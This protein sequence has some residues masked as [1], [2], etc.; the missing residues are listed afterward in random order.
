MFT[1]T[2]AI[3]LRVHPWSN[4][5]H[6]V[7]WLT[8]DYGR[9]TTRIKGACRP[10]SP[11]LGQYDLAYTCELIFYTRE[12]GGVHSIREVSPLNLRE[13][14]RHNWRAAATANYYI[15]LAARVT[16]PMQE[17]RRHF[18]LL[19][20][21][22]DALCAVTPAIPD[23][24]RHEARLLQLLGLFPN[25]DPCPHCHLHPLQSLRYSISSAKPL[26]AHTRPP[27]PS[28]TL[29]TLPLGV[30]HALSRLLNPALSTASSAEPFSAHDFSLG[31]RRFLGI[32]IRHHVELSMS[33]RRTL[34][35]L[36][37]SLPAV[38]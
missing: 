31:I 9:V 28:D 10:K 25:L 19:E 27:A 2:E 32:F 6:L 33:T 34:F 29:L 26:C 15:D 35:D 30:L 23:I 11:F 1:S 38:T 8:P 17:S 14:L 13:P 18:D 4:S 36:F 37:S 7:T 12:T 5:S 22:L 21:D 20:R 24:L 3:V 16:L